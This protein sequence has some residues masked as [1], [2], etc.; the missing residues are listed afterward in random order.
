MWFKVVMTHWDLFFKAWY[1]PASAQG[2]QYVAHPA[3][4]SLDKCSALLAV[5][6][7]YSNAVQHKGL[8]ASNTWAHSNQTTA[9][10]CDSATAVCATL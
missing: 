7:R 10:G 5:A 1:K 3:I 6:I 9:H 8:N 2:G 4:S